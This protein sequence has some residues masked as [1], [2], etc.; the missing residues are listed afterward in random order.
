MKPRRFAATTLAIAAAT[1]CL[2]AGAA[3]ASAAKPLQPMDI[4]DLETATDPQ[5]SPDGKHVVYVRRFADV[6]T[7]KRLANLWIVDADGTNHR[8]LDH[9]QAERR[10]AAVVARRQA[11]PVRLRSRRRRA[12]L[13]RASW[14]P[15]R[16][17]ASPT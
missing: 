11:A 13:S 6:M 15:A 5:I 1:A 16:P 14:T 10:L 8:P 12:D 2:A 4:F 3:T 7:D 9:R 17:R